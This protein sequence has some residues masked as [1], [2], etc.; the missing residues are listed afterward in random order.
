MR[1]KR[2]GSLLDFAL[3]RI[4]SLLRSEKN[5]FELLRKLFVEVQR[6]AMT[7]LR[8]AYLAGRGKYSK[9]EKLFQGRQEI[10]GLPKKDKGS[11]NY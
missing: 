6:Q 7:P 2:L 10:K 9:C 1:G 11:R 8:P 5:Q 4:L 3:H